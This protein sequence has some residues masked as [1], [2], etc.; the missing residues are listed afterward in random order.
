MSLHDLHSRPLDLQS[1]PATS[2]FRRRVALEPD[3]GTMLRRA[4]ARAKEGDRE[5][6]R[7][8]YLRYADN[9]HGY[10]RSIVSD[11]HEAEDVTQQV[12]AKLIKVIVKYEERDVPFSAWIFRVA[13]N[14]AVDH[15]R[16]TTATPCADIRGDQGPEDDTARDRARCL[17]DAL[18]HLPDDQRSVVVMR[19]V[20]GLTPVEIAARLGRSE[21]SVH[22]LHHRGRR[23]LKQEL[24]RMNAAPV[25]AAA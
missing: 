9:I 24:M 4:I 19:H 10:V 25:I 3:T 14:V 15:L 12:F 20:V 1:G 22:G 6:I 21:S 5:A 18:D 16:R 17:E 8:I 11:E 13:R 7:F 23:A 2:C